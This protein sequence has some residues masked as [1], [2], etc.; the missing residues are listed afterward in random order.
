M[1][2]IK[3]T[4]LTASGQV[5][6]KVSSGGNTLSAPARVLGLTVQC[7]ATEGRVD[8]IDN[9][10]GGTVK[11]SQVT[12]AIGSGEDE[13]LQID[14]PDMGLKFDT[15]LYVFFNQATKVNVIYG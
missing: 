2:G 8:L 9:G 14:F 11:F 15:D 13:I 6:T 7:G 1:F 3:T 4:Q 5:T 12:P 10:S